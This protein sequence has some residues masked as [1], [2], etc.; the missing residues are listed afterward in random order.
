MNLNHLTAVAGGDISQAM[1]FL[2]VVLSV[3]FVAGL[4]AQ[5]V[6]DVYADRRKETQSQ[7]SVSQARLYAAPDKAPAEAHTQMEKVNADIAKLREDV[8]AFEGGRISTW[9]NEAYWYYVGSSGKR[10]SYWS[11]GPGARYTVD[12]LNGQIAKL[13]ALPLPVMGPF[14]RVHLNQSQQVLDAIRTALGLDSELES[15]AR[16]YLQK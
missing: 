10:Y 6:S 9:N 4:S 11:S 7:F 12:K 2:P 14:S 3:A 13:R 15:M 16:K 1:R 5:S 8:L